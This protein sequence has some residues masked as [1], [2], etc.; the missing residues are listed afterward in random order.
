[1]GD[2]VAFVTQVHAQQVGDMDVVFDDQDT[3]GTAHRH[4]RLAGEVVGIV[5]ATA[6][7]RCN[8]KFNS[9]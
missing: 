5:G 4:A 2:V 3:F 8:E 1:M 9:A 6:H 7:A